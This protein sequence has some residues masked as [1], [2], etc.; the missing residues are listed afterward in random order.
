M[1]HLTS[2]NWKPAIRTYLL[3]GFAVLIIV[4]PSEAVAR[5]SSPF[6]GCYSDGTLAI[7]ISGGGRIS[8]SNYYVDLSGRIWDDGY[9]ELT[10]TRYFISFDRTRGRRSNSYTTFA[11]GY[12]ALDADGNLYGALQW[13]TGETSDFLWLRCQ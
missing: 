5:G 12:G 4:A 11:V 2:S 13:S 7:T 3:L 1:F 8:D 9:I 10:Y 6:A